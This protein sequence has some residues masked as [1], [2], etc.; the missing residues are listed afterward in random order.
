MGALNFSTICTN[1]PWNNFPFVQVG[2]CRQFAES[3][4]GRMGSMPN[5]LSFKTFKISYK[6]P[7]QNNLWFKDL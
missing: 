2:I 5:N 1:N 4:E 3:K 7:I 6:D